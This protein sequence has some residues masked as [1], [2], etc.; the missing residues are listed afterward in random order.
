MGTRAALKYSQ[1]NQDITVAG[2]GYAPVPVSSLPPAPG[3][4]KGSKC[5][6]NHGLKPVDFLPDVMLA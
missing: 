2:K 5:R 6:G 3:R 1:A 4:V